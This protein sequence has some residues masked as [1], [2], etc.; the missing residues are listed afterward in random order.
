MFPRY[1]NGH[2]LRRL[3]PVW[4]PDTETQAILIEHGIEAPPYPLA[5]EEAF[6]STSLAH[7]FKI[8]GS[9]MVT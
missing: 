6:P 9:R 2:F 1:P 7:P 3:G 8:P 5:V 4:D